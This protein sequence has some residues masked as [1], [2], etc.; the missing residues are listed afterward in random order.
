MSMLL[1]S[2]L[3]LLGQS[4][5]YEWSMSS[6]WHIKVVTGSKPYFR[7]LLSKIRQVLSLGSNI[8]YHSQVVKY[9]IIAR[10]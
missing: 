1:D 6:G 9:G 8:W 10:L 3:Q 5:E 7:H 4:F 2:K